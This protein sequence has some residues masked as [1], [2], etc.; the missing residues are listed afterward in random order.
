MT[1]PNSDLDIS[2]DV[3]FG[4]A[5]LA[6]D[7]VEGMTPTTPPVRM[8]EILTGR[9]AKGIQVERKEDAVRIFLS[10]RVTYGF[11]IPD[12]AKEAQGA[13]REAVSSMTGL[14]VDTVDVSVEAVDVP[15]TLSRG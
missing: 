6:L 1:T 3:L 13:V 8:G 4:I 2:Q 5:Q 12:L 10:V 14:E 9:R 11:P 7:K 15:E